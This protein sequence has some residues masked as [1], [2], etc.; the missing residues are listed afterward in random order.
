[1]NMSSQK[2]ASWLQNPGR[3]LARWA[4]KLHRDES[5]ATMLEWS[6]LLAAVGIPA[7]MLII[8]GLRIMAAHYDLVTGLNQMPFP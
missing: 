1:M 2:H 6:L 3:A 8:I 4:W 7:L 5:G